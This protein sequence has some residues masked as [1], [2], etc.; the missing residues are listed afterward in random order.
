[1]VPRLVLTPGDPVAVLEEAG[2]FAVL[3][4][5]HAE[6]VTLAGEGPGDVV[7]LGDAGARL[8]RGA[9]DRVADVVVDVQDRAEFLDLG[10]VQPF[11]VH[12][13]ELVGPDPAHAF[14]HVPQG[15]CQVHHPALAEQE[16]VF[17][18]LRQDLPELEGVL[19]DGRALVPEVVGADDGGVPGHVPAGQPALFQDRDVRHPV[20]LGQ[21]VGRRQAVAAAADNHRVVA[22]LRIRVA[23]EEVR[24]LRKLFGHHATSVTSEERLG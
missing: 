23:P 9:H 14:T 5:V 13:V 6:F 18:F 2:D 4:D 16:V 10:R 17:E 19:V 22:L 1:M 15:V 7:V 8:V 12:A 11:R 3:D 21:V 24:V 20:V